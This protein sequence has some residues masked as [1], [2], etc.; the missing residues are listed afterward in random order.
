MYRHPAKRQTGARV[1][2]PTSL[3]WLGGSLQSGSRGLVVI[4]WELHSLGVPGCPAGKW[5]P[6]RCFQVIFSACM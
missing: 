3:V 1:G 6:L 5:Q 2:T 4:C